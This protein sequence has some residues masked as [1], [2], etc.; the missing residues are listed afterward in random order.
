MPL[1]AFLSRF[2]SSRSNTRPELSEAQLGEYNNYLSILAEFFPEERVAVLRDLLLSA[3]YSQDSKLYAVSNALIENPVQPGE[4]RLTYGKLDDWQRIRSS[5][6]KKAVQNALYEEWKSLSKSTIK[7]VLVEN[8]YS[9]TKTRTSLSAI[10][11]KSWRVSFTNWLSKRAPPPAL[12]PRIVTN[13]QEL[14]DEISQLSK[15]DTSEQDLRLAREI[16]AAEY[17][18]ADSLLE[19]QCCYIDYAWEELRACGNG[20]FSCRTCISKIVEE[21]LFGQGSAVDFSRSLIKCIS[22]TGNEPCAFS[23]PTSDLR[24]VLPEEIW[25]ALEEHCAKEA[26]RESGV[27]SQVTRCPFC[28]YAVI[29]KVVLPYRFRKEARE[30]YNSL[31]PWILLASSLT[32]FLRYRLILVSAM[33]LVLG[34]ALLSSFWNL[35]SLVYPLPNRFFESRIWQL[36]R[37]LGRCRQIGRPVVFRCRNNTCSKSSCRNCLQ[38]WVGFHDCQDSKESLRLYVE[39]AQAEAIKRT[40]RISIIS[41]SISSLTQY[42]QCPNCGVSFVKESGCNKMVC[43]CG[44]AMCY[45]CRA[46]VRVEKYNHFCPHFRAI[47]G[48]PCAD[49]TRCNLYEAENESAI[50]K[51]AASMAKEE[52]IAARG[53]GRSVKGSEG[54]DVWDEVKRKLTNF[55]PYDLTT[56]SMNGAIDWTLLSLVEW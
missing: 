36:Q 42:D 10:A 43:V 52:W 30:L 50:L 38:E 1:P 28:S 14:A 47:P 39:R 29:D 46:D 37:R 54:P 33:P 5:G 6:Y 3:E 22:V 32:L 19:C 35:P 26:L 49:C 25:S 18:A 4:V 51:A 17:E 2:S 44:Y 48:R 20:H 45:L 8:N 12:P 23:M 9:Y 55:R 41:Q 21:S 11:S 53:S 15:A 7:T 31:S 16:N 13:N 56:W 40:V 27:E 24:A 34:R